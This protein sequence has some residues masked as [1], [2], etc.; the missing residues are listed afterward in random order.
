MNLSWQ[1]TLGTLKRIS[2]P[3]A[4]EDRYSLAASDLGKDVT[5][6]H[7]VSGFSLEPVLLATTYLMIGVPLAVAVLS[8]STPR[9]PM[10]VMRANWDGRLVEKAR[11]GSLGNLEVI[12]RAR[13][14]M[15]ARGLGRMDGGENRTVED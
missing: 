5:R 1:S 12:C 13:K 6:N 3:L 7:E 10:T 4:K 8:A 15:V 14:D 9:R 2:Y 11:V